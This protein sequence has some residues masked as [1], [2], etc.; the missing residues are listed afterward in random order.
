M[1]WEAPGEVN[2]SQETRGEVLVGE[3][4]TWQRG[5]STMLGSSKASHVKVEVEA[6]LAV[7]KEHWSP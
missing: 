1:W 7:L 3:N 4:G 2:D 6:V 5:Y